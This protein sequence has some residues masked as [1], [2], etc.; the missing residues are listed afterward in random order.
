M[1]RFVGLFR[2]GIAG[3]DTFRKFNIIF[4]FR[5]QRVHEVKLLSGKA[6]SYVYVGDAAAFGCSSSSS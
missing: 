2:R 1:S 4:D 3:S 6:T 5:K